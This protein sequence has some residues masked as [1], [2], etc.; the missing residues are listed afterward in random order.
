MIIKLARNT[1]DLINLQ[2]EFPNDTTFG[3]TSSGNIYQ[4]VDGQPTQI[5]KNDLDT[6]FGYDTQEL[7]NKAIN[8]ELVNTNEAT[9]NDTLP[10]TKI[11]PGKQVEPGNQVE[12]CN[13]AEPETIEALEEL[14][15]EDPTVNVNIIEPTLGDTD[16]LE[17]L[18]ERVATLEKI[19]L[20]IGLA[21]K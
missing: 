16:K 2:N 15:Q 5:F 8:G 6:I 14:I 9:T 17:A 12:P 1:E 10:G 18:E 20:N 19:V 21:F 13:Q 4:L 3:I 11:E 7:L